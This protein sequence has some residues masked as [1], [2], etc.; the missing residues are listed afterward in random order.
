MEEP[1]GVHGAL[2]AD[3]DMG[4]DVVS[5]YP[6]NLSVSTG[7]LLSIHSPHDV[8]C[9]CV[10]VSICDSLWQPGEEGYVQTG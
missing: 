1:L 7:T 9:E 6:N 3:W 4:L 8:L 5:P 10:C 2:S